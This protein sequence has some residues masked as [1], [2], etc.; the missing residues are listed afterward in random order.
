MGSAGSLSN[1]AHHVEASSSNA[2]VTLAHQSA[3]GE[4]VHP[5]SSSLRPDLSSTRLAHCHERQTSYSPSR[6]GRSTEAQRREG[7]AKYSI[8][9]PRNNGGELALL[10]S[11]VFADLLVRL[12]DLF[13]QKPKV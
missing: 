7:N 3:T 8:G 5:R 13:V 11:Q 12:L 2:L 4:Q 6:M 10:N 9:A 1:Q